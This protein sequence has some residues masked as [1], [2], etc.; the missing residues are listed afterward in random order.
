MAHERYKVYYTKGHMVTFRIFH[1]KDEAIRFAQ[2]FEYFGYETS[3]WE[4]CSM[5]IRKLTF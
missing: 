5:G 3:L 1:E 2:F 4:E